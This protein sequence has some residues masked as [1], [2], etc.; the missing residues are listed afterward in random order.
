MSRMYHQFTKFLATEVGKRVF[1]F[2]SVAIWAIVVIVSINAKRGFFLGKEID[3]GNKADS[4]FRIEVR[5]E[6]LDLKGN[7][8]VQVN[9]QQILNDGIDSIIHILHDMQDD[10]QELEEKVDKNSERIY[11]LNKK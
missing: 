3:A 5:G 2:A 7:D 6:I 11:E 8:A 9:N 1:Q 10:Q 4:L